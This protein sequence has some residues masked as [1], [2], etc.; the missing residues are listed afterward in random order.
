MAL[1]L[2]VDDDRVVRLAFGAKLRAKGHRVIEA[3]GGEQALAFVAE[4]TPDLVVTDVVMP[5]MDGWA[6][7]RALR[8]QPSMALVPVLFLTGLDSSDDRMRGF[9]LG[10]DDFIPKNCGLDEVQMRVQRALDRAQDVDRTIRSGM[11]KSGMMGDL[12]VIGPAS[13]LTLLDME[14][15]TGELFLKRDAVEVRLSLRGGRIVDAVVVGNRE[16]IGAECVYL[17][18]TWSSGNFF[19]SGGDIAGPDRIGIPTT[20]LLM[21]GARRMDEGGKDAG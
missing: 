2:L 16:I 15:R 9:K 18:F 11:G 21:E 7:V 5:G 19:L 17:V 8:S 14:K 10:A 6:L 4:E 12:S 1:I 20:H 13:L 3:E